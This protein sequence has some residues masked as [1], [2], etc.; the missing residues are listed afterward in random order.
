MEIESNKTY[1][2]KILWSKTYIAIGVDKKQKNKSTRPIT[3]LYF[4]PR[5][6]SWKLLKNELDN[7]PWLPNLDKIEILN[8]YNLII[9]YWLNNVE[10][11]NLKQIFIHSKDLN[12][13]IIG[14]I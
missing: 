8:T 6:D 12:F 10:I 1:L 5:E 7:K 2:F 13:Q 11:T 14:T 3:E 4:W 9:N